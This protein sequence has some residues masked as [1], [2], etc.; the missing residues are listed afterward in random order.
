MKQI[1]RFLLNFFSPVTSSCLRRRNPLTGKG[2]RVDAPRRV[3]SPQSRRSSKGATNFLPLKTF[4]QLELNSSK[5]LQLRKSLSL[6]NVR[7]WF[8][9]FVSCVCN[10]TLFRCRGTGFLFLAGKPEKRERKKKDKKKKITAKSSQFYTRANETPSSPEFRLHVNPETD[11]CDSFR[12]DFSDWFSACLAVEIILRSP[13]KTRVSFPPSIFPLYLP[14]HFFPHSFSPTYDGILSIHH[15]YRT[16]IRPPFNPKYRIFSAVGG[17]PFP[18]P[19]FSRAYHGLILES[20]QVFHNSNGIL[21]PLLSC[22][23]YKWC[24]AYL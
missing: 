20:F 4:T 19:L 7:A 8:T 6:I 11:D 5:L 3:R 23:L 21:G 24:F 17:A 22:V 9:C 13:C 15:G 1:S 2:R 14:Q 18:F 10:A 16:G 12:R